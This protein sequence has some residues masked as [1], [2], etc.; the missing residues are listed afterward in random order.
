MAGKPGGG[1][2]RSGS[3]IGTPG[4]GGGNPGGSAAGPTNKIT[5]SRTSQ[6]PDLICA[7]GWPI[8]RQATWITFEMIGLMHA[9][10]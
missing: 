9:H 1:R 6:W 10:T 8:L 3:C 5:L 2:D 7:I 4:G